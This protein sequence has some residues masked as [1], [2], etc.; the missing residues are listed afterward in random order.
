MA[1]LLRGACKY[2]LHFFHFYI[3]YDGSVPLVRHPTCPTSHLFDNSL[4]Q[5]PTCPTNVGQLRRR[6]SETP[7]CST[8]HM[9]DSSLVRNCTSCSTNQEKVSLFRH[10][11]FPNF[12]E[13]ANLLRHPTCP[14]N[15]GLVVQNLLLHKLFH[16]SDAPVVRQILD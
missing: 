13:L 4:V 6:T 2:F 8:S 7:S 5:H 15:F 3:R 9:S 14:T 10:P 16:F 12:V 1:K 11:I